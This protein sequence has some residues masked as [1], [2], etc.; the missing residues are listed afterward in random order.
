MGPSRPV[1]EINGDLGGKMHIFTLVYA[2]GVPLEFC[3]GGGAHKLVMSLPNGPKRPMPAYTIVS[4]QYRYGTDR[5]TDRQKCHDSITLRML[6][7]AD[8]R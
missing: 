5:Q 8:A 3:N 1:S 2:E 4:T 7:D 6:V